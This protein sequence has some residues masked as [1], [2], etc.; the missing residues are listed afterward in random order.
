MQN[1]ETVPTMTPSPTTIPET[2]AA[3]APRCLHLRAKTD[4]LAFDPGQPPS[5]DADENAGS[6]GDA[7]HCFCLRTLTVIGPDDDIVG[8]RD[9]LPGRTC[10]ES[11]GF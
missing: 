2:V 1:V 4:Y 11:S 8:P 9:C 3:A 7:A 6:G 5:G 10:Y